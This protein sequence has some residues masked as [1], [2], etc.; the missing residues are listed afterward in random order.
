MKRLK[1]WLSSSYA[2]DLRS[3]AAFRVG[4]GVLVLSDLW[5]RAQ[6]G[7][8]QAFHTDA[9]VL[10]RT[11][12]IESIGDA[13]RLTPQLLSGTSQGTAWV[14]AVHALLGLGLLLGWKSRLMA[15]GCWFLT[16]GLQN[17]TPPIVQGGDLYFRMQLLI[18]ALLPVGSAFS[19]DRLFRRYEPD[20]EKISST[21]S[22]AATFLLV[23]QIT[24]VYFFAG[25]LKWAE[26]DWQAGL[27]TRYALLALQFATPFSLKLSQWKAFTWPANWATVWGEL[28]IPLVAFFLPLK[29]RP[30][31]WVWAGILALA[32]LHLSI[33]LFLQVGLFGAISLV[34]LLALIPGSFWKSRNRRSSFQGVN[35]FYD[36]EC[37]VCWRMIVLLHR[38]LGFPLSLARPAQSEPKAYSLMEKE[39]SWVLQTGNGSFFTRFDG[40]LELLSRTRAPA[41]QLQGRISGW[42][43]IRSIGNLAYRGFASHRP[44]MSRFVP[45]L[46]SNAPK[47]PGISASLIAA[48]V[49]VVIFLFNWQTLPHQSGK[50]LQRWIQS[51][52]WI[53]MMGLDQQWGMFSK[54]MKDPGWYEIQGIQAN[55]NELD[56]LTRQNKERF[57]KR[58]EVISDTFQ[59]DRWR[60]YWV[61]LLPSSSQVHRLNFGKYLCREWNTKLSAH[62]RLET[63]DIVYYRVDLGPEATGREA[64]TPTVLWRHEC[65]SGA[66]AKWGRK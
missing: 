18:A 40:I 30:D 1:A 57:G 66:A 13:W 39:N 21:F 29:K 54:P 23:L 9:G 22:S 5:I 61:N 53:W 46:E 41:W 48:F 6:P 62:E 50:P 7:L 56:L 36:G 33:S 16:L 64:A 37:G 2:L 31:A 28:L 43:P 63:F 10:P 27:G 65:L 35:L 8:F 24:C 60:K 42:S 11:V 19:L 14:F 51:Q 34:P 26:P 55:G 17:R 58:P 3:L 47:E 12:L 20:E 25:L 15:L 38:I 49:S 4:L 45:A 52:R 59:G 32:G 44:L